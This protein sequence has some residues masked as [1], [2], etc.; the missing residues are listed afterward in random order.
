MEP[1]RERNPR[2][3]TST[4][5][6]VIVMKCCVAAV[7]IVTDDADAEVVVVVVND[8][9]SGFFS[10]WGMQVSLSDV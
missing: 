2:E 4:R 8:Q 7:A 6:E 9:I 10:R 1:R 5:S 3:R